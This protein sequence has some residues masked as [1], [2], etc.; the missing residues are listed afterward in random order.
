MNITALLDNVVE[1]DETLLV[2]LS[3]EDPAVT[4]SLLSAAVTIVD[5]TG[6]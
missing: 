2:M 3:S 6:M 5:T 4:L 1:N